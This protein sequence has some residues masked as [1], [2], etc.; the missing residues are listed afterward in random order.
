MP[1]LERRQAIVF[2]LVVVIVGLILGAFA[3]DTVGWIYTAAVVTVVLGLVYRARRR[4]R[5]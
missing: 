4:A 5:P 3:S 1:V 2:V